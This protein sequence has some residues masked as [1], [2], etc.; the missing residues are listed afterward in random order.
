MTVS[1]T[2]NSVSYTGDDVTDDFPTVFVFNTS[3]DIEVIER[4][5][6]TGAE[7]TKVLTTDY[8]VAGG[9]GAG[10]EPATGTVTAVTAPASTVEW[11][12]RRVVAETQ[13]EDLPT[14]GAFPSVPV[15]TQLD[16]QVM[17]IQ[18]HSGEIARALS[19]PKTDDSSLSNE[20]PNSVDRAGKFLKFTS[21][22]ALT[23]DSSTTSDFDDGTAALP[24]ITFLNDDDT[25]FFLE[26]VGQL[27]ITVAGTRRFRFTNAQIQNQDGS[28]SVPSYGFVDDTDTGMSRPGTNILSFSTGGSER[29]RVDA[30][31]NV[32]IGGTTAG[33]TSAGNLNLINGTAPTD[34]PAEGVVLYAEDVTA[35]SEL[36]VMDEAANSTTLSPH[37]FELFQPDPADP[38][39]WSYYSRND[40]L[41]MEVNADLSGALRALEALTG[42]TFIYYRNVDK[43][44][45]TVAKRAAADALRDDLVLM[46]MKD[47]GETR[48]A[49]RKAIPAI[50]AK[51]PP[52]WL[53]ARGVA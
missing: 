2:T 9:G 35:S 43:R 53:A 12:I 44:D 39:P 15:E 14:A 48:A 45:W 13:T 49:A 20:I 30:S 50:A 8:T 29:V 25:G 33:A 16:R 46:R 21:T 32:I 51:A 11:H 10:A 23:V 40:F 28:V 41:G 24:S 47:R 52:A 19:F 34:G 26:A 18:Q 4:T 42:Q 7:E 36:K 1:V 22:G 38:F 27:S 6:A 37:R 31:G 17:M 3:A 5:I